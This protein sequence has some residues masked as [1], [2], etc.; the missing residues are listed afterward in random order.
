[1]APAQAENVSISDLFIS[2][3]YICTIIMNMVFLIQ[4]YLF[5]LF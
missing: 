3:Y 2:I 5:I 1:M 4:I